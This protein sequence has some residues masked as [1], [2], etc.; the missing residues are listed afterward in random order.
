MQKRV[1][2][3]SLSPPTKQLC[4]RRGQRM[5][6]WVEKGRRLPR[7]RRI[8]SRKELDNDWVH[9]RWFELA[10]SFETGLGITVAK[11]LSQTP[12]IA[13]SAPR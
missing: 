2:S 7:I 3:R 10:R 13:I 6:D 4:T 12:R 1:L 5:C 11:V 9:H 8:L